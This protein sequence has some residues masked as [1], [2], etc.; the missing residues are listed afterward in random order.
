MEAAISMVTR[1]ASEVLGI[2]DEVGTLTPGKDAD[3]TIFTNTN[4]PL[5]LGNVTT[6]FKQG[7]M[8]VQDGNIVLPGYDSFGS[9]NA[10]LNPTKPIGS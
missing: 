1:N 5:M 4:D 10:Y 8:L 2:S 9:L 7:K 6:V 3:I